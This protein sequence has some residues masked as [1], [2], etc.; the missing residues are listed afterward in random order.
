MTAT[1][2]ADLYALACMLRSAR[3][4]AGGEV[5]VR[6]VIGSTQCGAWINSLEAACEQLDAEEEDKGPL[7]WSRDLTREQWLVVLHDDEGRRRMVPDVARDLG[8]SEQTVRKW[9]KYHNIPNLC[10]TLQIRVW[11]G[12]ENNGSSS[13]IDDPAA[14]GT[15]RRHGGADPGAGGEHPGRALALR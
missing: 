5:P 14:P 7:I 3:E 6:L 9:I 8:C 4:V 12:G 1:V 10:E 11:D 13:T 15:D 2:S